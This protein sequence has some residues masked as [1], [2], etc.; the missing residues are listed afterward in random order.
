MTTRISAQQ[1][2]RYRE[3]VNDAIVTVL[4]ANCSWWTQIENDNRI[5]LSEERLG[6]KCYS[7]RAITHVDAS[8]SEITQSL[9]QT[10]AQSFRYFMRQV[11]GSSFSDG[12]VLF[13]SKRRCDIDESFGLKWAAFHLPFVHQGMDMC[14]ID[15]SRHLSGDPTRPSEACFIRVLETVFVPG[16]DDVDLVNNFQRCAI[17]RCAFIVRKNSILE[18]VCSV[19][20]EDMGFVQR[21]CRRYLLRHL[22]RSIGNFMNVILSTRLSSQLVTLNQWVDNNLRK[23]CV[24]CHRGFTFFRRRHHC[25]CCGEVRLPL[26]LRPVY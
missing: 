24:A 20:I 8:T 6:R 18:F 25:R 2:E 22:A 26:N 19:N 1:E 14:F 7:V 4:K 9:V 11:Y 13:Q 15:Y 5:S 17:T 21:H 16:S 10:D 12:K 23:R 3:L